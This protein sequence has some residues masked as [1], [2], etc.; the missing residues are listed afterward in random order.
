[1]PVR[2]DPSGETI[3]DALRSRQIGTHAFDVLESLDVRVCAVDDRLVRK[4]SELLRE[5]CNI[6]VEPSGA[7]AMGAVLGGAIGRETDRLL[8]IAC[9]GNMQFLDDECRG[10]SSILAGD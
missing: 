3:C 2:I 9:G 6:R 10:G 5:T 4:A 8:V 1:M 7:L